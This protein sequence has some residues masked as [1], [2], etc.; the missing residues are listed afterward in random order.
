MQNICKHCGRVGVKA[1]NLCV[2]HYN[3]FHKFGKFLDNN[4]R[5]IYDPNIYRILGEFTEVDTFD[6]FGD[7]NYTFLIDTENL[8]YVI[9][10]KWKAHINKKTNLVYLRNN[11]LGLFHKVIMGNPKQSIDHIS[12]NTLDNTKRN[13]KIASST[14]QLHNTR[15]R[16][17]E[18]D[19]KGIC[20]NNRNTNKKYFSR[21]KTNHKIYQSPYYV[22]YEEAV[23]ARYLLEQLAKEIIINNDMIPY[24]NKLSK[25]QRDPII[26]WF[27]NRFKNKL[28]GSV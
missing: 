23:F 7:V 28:K 17:S 10:Y 3:Q 11:E 5:T 2:K 27:N 21:F 14:Q 1:K 13:L 26:K 9:K 6:I 15:K 24:I 8:D 12:R 16:N 20:F 18:F 25:E 4:P 22:T 19:I